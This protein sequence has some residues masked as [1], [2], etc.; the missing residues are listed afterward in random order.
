MA[1]STIE[2]SYEKQ[3]QWLCYGI[4]KLARLGILT[5]TLV[6]AATSVADLIARAYTA[7]GTAAVPLY[8]VEARILVREFEQGILLLQKLAL[9]DDT[10]A[11]ALT[12]VNTASA[13]TDLRYLASNVITLN[14][15][16]PAQE[17]LS[18]AV[19]AQSVSA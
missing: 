3:L 13:A 6:A 4:N 9:I 5:T 19:F 14:G 7:L 18:D 12:T 11:A 15:F 16:D 1:N 8:E 10:I 2:V 17:P